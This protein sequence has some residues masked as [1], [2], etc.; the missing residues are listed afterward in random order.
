MA[1]TQIGTLLDVDFVN[2]K[3]AKL[4]SNIGSGTDLTTPAN[5]TSITALD[6]RLAAINGTYYTQARL[7]KMNVNDKV[8]AV[9]LND[10]AGSIK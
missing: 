6:T 10:D 9:R 4:K 7:D 3:R 8:Y 1:Q 5:Y 2:A